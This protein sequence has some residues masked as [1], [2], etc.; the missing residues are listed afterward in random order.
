MKIPFGNLKKQYLT[1]KEDIDK[2]IAKVLASG[3][4]ILGKE[5][6]NFEK[7][8]AKFCGVKYAVGVANGL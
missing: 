2:A 7:N 4:F 3:W 5:V 6:Q 8:F 1:V